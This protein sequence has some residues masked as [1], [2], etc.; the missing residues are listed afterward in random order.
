MRF[1]FGLVVAMSASWTAVAEEIV[2][3]PG[4]TIIISPSVETKVSCSSRNQGGI[5]CLCYE[6][7]SAS[8]VLNVYRQKS[9]SQSERVARIGVYPNSNEGFSKCFEDL[10]KNPHCKYGENN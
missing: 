6:Y 5:Y 2:I 10:V 7:S 4:S 8:L 1:L 3:T 9:E